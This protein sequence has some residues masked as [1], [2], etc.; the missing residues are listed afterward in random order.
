MD[1]NEVEKVTE[2]KVPEKSNEIAKTYAGSS[3]SLFFT[4]IFLFSALLIVSCLCFSSLLGELITF[5]HNR[6][7]LNLEL[8]KL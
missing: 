5:N 2:E 4:A 8:K 7:S 3:Y 1:Y 6:D